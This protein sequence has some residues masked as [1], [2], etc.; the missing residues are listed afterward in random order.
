MGSISV[1]A[2]MFTYVVAGL[3]VVVVVVVVVVELLVVAVR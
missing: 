2:G 1:P 3:A